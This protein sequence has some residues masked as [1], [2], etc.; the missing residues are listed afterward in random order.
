MKKGIILLLAAITHLSCQRSGEGYTIRLELEDAEGRWV[1]LAAIEDREYVVLDSL[2]VEPGAESLITGNIEG[3]RTVYLSVSGQE[4]TLRMLL[5]N[6]EYTIS[7]NLEDP[8]IETTGKAQNDLNSYDQITSP[9]EKRLSLTAEEYYAALEAGDQAKSDSLLTIYREV[10]AEMQAADSVYLQENPASF[11][12][13]LVLRGSFFTLDTD[14]LEEALESL[15]P[16]LHQ[17]EEYGYMHGLMLNQKK[18]AVGSPFTD[19]G[20]ETPG[21]E[22]LRISDVHNGK[23]LLIDFWASWCGPCR[24]ANPDLVALYNEFHDRGFEILGVSLDDDRESWLKAIEEDGLNWHQISD[25]K[26]WECEGAR[27]YGVPAIPHTVLVD[28]E[29]IISAKKLHGQ[30]LRAAIESLL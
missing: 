24:R 28:R 30:E 1:N 27:L 8:L 21:G 23:V 16:A 13:V 20:L 18:V 11:A 2:L 14:Q 19:F 17:M 3:V 15:D 10:H 5:E 22:M 9:I 4:G 12:S 25:V 29:G 26:G 6:A 7:G